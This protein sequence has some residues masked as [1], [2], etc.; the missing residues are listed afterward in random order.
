MTQVNMYANLLVSAVT[1]VE[2]VA[3]VVA[4]AVAEPSFVNKPIITNNTTE[5]IVISYDNDPTE[6]TEFY[7]KTLESQGW[8]YKLIGQGEVWEGFISK[9]RGYNNVLKTLPD[10]QI[11]VITDARDVLCV[12][13]PKAFLEG[14]NEF[15]SDII[16]SMELYCGGKLDVNEDFRFDQCKPLH[17]YWRF[18]KKSPFPAR[19]FVNSGLIAG[20]V[21]ALRTMFTWIVDGGFTDDQY[22]V[23]SYMTTF[24]DRVAADIDASLLHTTT[25]AVNAGILSIHIQKHDSPTFAEIYGRGAFFLHIPG[26]ARKGQTGPS[27]TGQTVVYQALKTLIADGACGPQLAKA[28]GWPEPR[29]NKL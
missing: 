25:F 27:G 3:A 21:S 20:K 29:W 9:I 4:V 26:L 2:T 10:D 11:V 17:S 24:P 28:Y 18:H 8:K 22:A 13:C 14:Y 12:R 7:I 19:K 23:G 6:N 16:V 1:A 5:P 15:K